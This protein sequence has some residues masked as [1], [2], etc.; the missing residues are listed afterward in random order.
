[1]TAEEAKAFGLMDQVLA[2]RPDIADPVEA[3][4]GSPKSGQGLGRY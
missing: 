2:R 3:L 4:V 1:M